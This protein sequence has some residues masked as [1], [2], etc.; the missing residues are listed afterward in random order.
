[1]GHPVVHFEVQGA[2]REALARFYQQLFDWKTNDQSEFNY[3]LVE[4]G[5][6]GGINGGI[7]VTPD[8]APGGVTF[9]VHSDDGAESL[10]RAEELGRSS[11][12]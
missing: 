7:G 12:Q 3:T 8:G 4:T 5:G 9:Y 11:P 1:M 10:R 6:E 2:D